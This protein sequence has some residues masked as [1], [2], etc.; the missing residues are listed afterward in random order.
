[1]TFLTTLL[2]TLLT[3]FCVCGED[4]WCVIAGLLDPC[5]LYTAFRFNKD[6][7]IPPKQIIMEMCWY[8]GQE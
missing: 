6:M 3:I 8:N 5:F 2:T 1:M 4:L 7:S